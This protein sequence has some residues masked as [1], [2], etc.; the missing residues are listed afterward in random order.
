L[1]IR[2]TQDLEIASTASKV[3]YNLDAG[4]PGRA[5]GDKRHQSSLYAG[6]GGNVAD[7]GQDGGE[8]VELLRAGPQHIGGRVILDERA[9]VEDEAVDGL[10]G[11]WLGRGW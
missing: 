7:F 8:D 5:D 4:R 1:Y 10:G 6:T 2:A 9:R 11:R 3:G